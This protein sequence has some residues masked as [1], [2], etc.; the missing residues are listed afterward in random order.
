M[1]NSLYSKYEKG[2]ATTS[3]II[4]VVV[5]ILAGYAFYKMTEKQIEEKKI[6]N[7]SETET[8]VITQ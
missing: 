4:I 6:E 2:G 5:L 3:I 7:T 1:R 8:T